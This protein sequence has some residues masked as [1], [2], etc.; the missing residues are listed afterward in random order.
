MLREL[1]AKYLITH[2]I[3]S[4]FTVA[5]MTPYMDNATLQ[6]SSL[7]EMRLMLGNITWSKNIFTTY[8]VKDKYSLFS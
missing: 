6:S 4:A 3:N 1:A 7:H 5:S 8:K 2:V